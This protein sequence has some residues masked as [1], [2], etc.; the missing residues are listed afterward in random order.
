MRRFNA[1]FFFSFFIQVPKKEKKES[2]VKAPHSKVPRYNQQILP[3]LLNF[4]AHH[5]DKAIGDFAKSEAGE[6]TFVVDTRG[7][8]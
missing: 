6:C 4:T 3:E 2:G 1:A 5:V 8:W 7:L